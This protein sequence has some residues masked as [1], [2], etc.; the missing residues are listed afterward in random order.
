MQII[1]LLKLLRSD[2]AVRLSRTEGMEF[3]HNGKNVTEKVRGLDFAYVAE[4]DRL[5]AAASHP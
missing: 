3:F 4:L 2:V 5:I 1:D